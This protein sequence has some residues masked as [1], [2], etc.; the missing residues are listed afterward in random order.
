MN[1]AIPAAGTTPTKKDEAATVTQH[2]W[3]GFHCESRLTRSPSARTDPVVLVGGAFQTKGGWGRVER[4]FL[5]F[6]DVLTVDLPGWG[7]SPV[8]PE[9]YGITFLAD[10]LGHILDDL[11]LTA[12]NLFGNSYGTAVTYQLAQQR[13]DLVTRMVLSGTMT[14]LP[15]GM[16]SPM[17]R[18]IE[19]GQAGRTA[20]SAEL[21]VS[22]LMNLDAIDSVVAGEQVRRFF[23]RRLQNL[24]AHE[25]EQF[26]EN[27]RRL[28]RYM[29]LDTSRPPAM[30]VLVVVGEHDHFTT[31][32]MCRAVAETCVDSR[33]AVISQADHML[34]LERPTE[35]A[36][37]STR[38][39][40][41]DP[42]EGLDYL[43]GI[44][45]TPH[46]P[47]LDAP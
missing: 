38:F 25:K 40:L 46:V 21:G 41:D 45:R 31:P 23:L 10:A 8:L 7:T 30:P 24:T 11:G 47:V 16:R 29:R 43:R 19:L 4:E 33:F 37:L 35:L 28:F 39:F 15:D 20:E 27:T 9:H 13:P 2:R 12:V 17:R 1:S 36:D 6:A 42:L 26:V 22:S 32:D 5:R 3:A 34:L 14:H 18:G 44:E